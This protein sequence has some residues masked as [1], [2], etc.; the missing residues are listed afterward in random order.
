MIKLFARSGKYIY[1]FLV[2]NKFFVI[3]STMNVSVEDSPLPQ[4]RVLDDVVDDDG[5]VL[6]PHDDR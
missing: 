4:L 3:I 6:E 1:S 2:L 5:A